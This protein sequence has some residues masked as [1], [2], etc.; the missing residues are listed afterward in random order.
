MTS[1]KRFG[2]D[3]HLVRNVDRQF[4]RDR[5][6]DLQ[7]TEGQD[8]TIDL[9]RYEGTDN[10]KQALLLRFLTQT[11][12][13]A[14]LGHPNYGSRLHELIGELNNETNRNRAKLFVLQSL[15]AEPRVQEIRSVRVTERRRTEIQIDVEVVSIEDGSLVNLVFPFSLQQS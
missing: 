13:L 3:L 10:L 4:D 8:S 2:T 11:G 1:N 9:A 12:E 6:R 5:G 14:A 15:S 7:T